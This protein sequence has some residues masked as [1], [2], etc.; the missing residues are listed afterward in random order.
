MKKIKYKKHIGY[1]RGAFEKK[2]T[3]NL[4]IDN[5]KCRYLPDY[6][7]NIEDRDIFFLGL[8]LYSIQLQRFNS[9]IIISLKELIKIV[10]KFQEKNK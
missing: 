1:L 3:I 2:N 6:V 10:L 5:S 8:Y 7:F 4:K 9:K